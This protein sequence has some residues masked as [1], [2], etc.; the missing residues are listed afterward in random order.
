MPF[1][2][3][4]YSCMDA[5]IPPASSWQSCI[6]VAIVSLLFFYEF[7]LTNI[8]NS[9]G[10]FITQT[11]NLSPTKL[12]FV[13]SLYFYTNLI[14]LIPASVL[15]DRYSPRLV[16][17]FVLFVA[18][19]AVLMTAFAHST[20][21]VIISRLLMGFSGGFSLV[22][23]LRIAINW[24]DP[25]YLAGASGFTVGVGFLG[26]LTVQTPLTLLIIHMGWREATIIVGLV[27]YVIMGLIFIVVRDAPHQ[28]MPSL[29]A[30]KIRHT[31]TGALKCLKMALLKKQN[32]FCG[33]YTSLM[34]LPIF[35]LGALWGIPYLTAVQG[36]SIIQAATVSGMLYIGTMI[37]SPILG[38][39]SDLIGS[40]TRPMQIAA[41]L[42]L[43]LILVVISL[44]HAGFITFLILFLLLGIITAAQIISYPTV[45]ESNDKMIS[46]SAIAIISI[47]CM[48]GGALIQP[49]FG[50]LLA[51]K[52]HGVTMPLA[53]YPAANYQFAMHVLPI[54]FVIALILSFFI[55]D[56]KGRTLV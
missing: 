33:L 54:T 9:L 2:L 12:G 31:Q 22:G 19:T 4:E 14:F 55:Y 37:G 13:A 5:K 21:T 8:Y 30:R 45:A 32:W 53:H 34:N 18:A 39:I 24:L 3:L 49:L 38:S 16:I 7:A 26:G 1:P 27:G 15:L 43:I 44:N 52:S 47:M 20:S 50:Y 35:M 11:F 48:G 23:C 41:F 46:S 17:T 25:K 51:Y 36:L 42:S 10:P 6:V 29:K 40:R 28:E 56:T